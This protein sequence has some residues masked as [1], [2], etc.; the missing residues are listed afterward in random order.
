MTRS[1]VTLAF[2]GALLG[3]GAVGAAEPIRVY[4]STDRAYLLDLA[5]PVRKLAV[6]NPAIADV[7]VISPTQVLVNARSAGAT[8]LVVFHARTLETFEVVVHAGP[9]AVPRAPIVPDA[10][11]AVLVQRA[12][13]LTNQLFARDSDRAWIELGTVKNEVD[14]DARPDVPRPELPTRK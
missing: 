1:L 13:R 7:H 3:P 14:A 6:A 10:P 4:V 5:E 9:V 12:D 11:H 8:S 2:L